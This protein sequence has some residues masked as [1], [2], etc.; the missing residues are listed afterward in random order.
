MNNSTTGNSEQSPAVQV[1]GFRVD[2]A[3]E[4]LGSA[5]L[6]GESDERLSE[7]SVPYIPPSKTV[8]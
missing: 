8:R 3:Q 7:A 6:E 1:V 2:K 4:A 5:H